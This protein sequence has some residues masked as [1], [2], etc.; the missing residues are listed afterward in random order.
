MA[1]S[2]ADAAIEFVTA[3]AEK[4]RLKDLRCDMLQ[5]LQE[6]ETLEGCDGQNPSEGC[7]KEM[8]NGQLNDPTQFC[9]YCTK[10]HSVCVA[11]QSASSK[12]SGKLRTLVAA[13]K[14]STA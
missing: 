13:V 9:E 5:K 3:R 11:Y 2:I 1:K 14:R 8:L 12:A 10:I 4:L 7:H 6:G